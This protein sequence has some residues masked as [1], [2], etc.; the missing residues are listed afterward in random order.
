VVSGNRVGARDTELDQAGYWTARL[1]ATAR[2]GL[3]GAR[4][5]AGAAKRAVLS[6]LP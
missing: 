1:R 3:D 2:W 5:V 4:W 6:V